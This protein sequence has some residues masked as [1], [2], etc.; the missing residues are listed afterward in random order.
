MS[1]RLVYDA[2]DLHRAAGMLDQA[3][4]VARQVGEEAGGLAPGSSACGHAGLAAAAEHFLEAWSYGMEVIAEDAGELGAVLRE[5]VT[6]YE[7]VDAAGAAALQ[8]QQR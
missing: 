8:Q 6:G 4:Q 5:A 3:V 2:G 1:F 7:S